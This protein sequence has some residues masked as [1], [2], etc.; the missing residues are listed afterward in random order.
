M[1]SYCRT[2]SSFSDCTP[3]DLVTC[4]Q[5]HHTRRLDTRAKEPPTRMPSRTSLWERESPRDHEMHLAHENVT[6]LFQPIPAA[7]GPS[8][9]TRKSNT[10]PDDSS[11]RLGDRQVTDSSSILHRRFW[12]E[13]S[14]ENSRQKDGIHSSSRLIEVTSSDST[15]ST[16]AATS[17]PFDVM[18]RI[19]GSFSWHDL[20]S[21][22]CACKTWNK[23]LAPL[24]EGMLFLHW[25]K[26]FKH[27]H[28]VAK[29]L[30]KAL[31]S[32]TKGAVR[33][34]AAAMVDAGLLLWELVGSLSMVVVL[35][36]SHFF[37]HASV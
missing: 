11:H 28:G 12:T 8:L 3:I 10:S 14:N 33:G 18:Q 26:K 34:C 21:A 25:G 5:R 31:Q 4:R 35:A 13:K 27:G 20:W 17:L 16:T 7:I 37:P 9:S 29:N 6:P 36:A 19:A 2:E 15:T 22:T 32:F 30:D 23:A 1:A 24:R